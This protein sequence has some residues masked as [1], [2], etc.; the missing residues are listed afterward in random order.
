MGVIFDPFQMTRASIAIER[1]DELHILGREVKI[2]ALQILDDA[3]LCDRFWND[4][5]ATL[6]L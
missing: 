2:G 4:N 6:S 1:I 3:L 5:H